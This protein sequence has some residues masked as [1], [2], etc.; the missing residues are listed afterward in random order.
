MSNVLFVN[1]CMRGSGISRTRVLCDKFLETLT[2]LSPCLDLQEYD[3]TAAPLS[4]LTASDI[5]IREAPDVSLD[6]PMFAPARAFADADLIVIGAPY[7]DLSFPAALKAFAE[8]I[9]VKGITFRYGEEG[10]AIGLCKAKH[11]VYLTTSGGFM[12]QY[13]F[14][15]DYWSALG[16]TMFG[17]E[18]S[19]CLT[20]EGLDIQELDASAAMEAALKKIPAL[21]QTLLS[22]L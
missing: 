17:I 3:L 13:N 12:G 11:L 22:A 1:A 21:C 18:N 9:S 16:R 4:P 6:A 14:G 20:C 19:C 2:A 10:G 15:Y 5:A 7:W 8:H